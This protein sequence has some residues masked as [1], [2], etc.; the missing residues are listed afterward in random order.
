MEYIK[1]FIEDIIMAEHIHTILVMDALREPGNC[2]FCAMYDKLE[3]NSI[4]FIMGPAYM[5][6]DVRMATDKVGF[7]N[8]HLALMYKEQNRL[9]LGLML[10]SHIKKIVNDMDKIIKSPISGSFFK[11]E[12]SNSLGKMGAYLKGINESCYICEKI[13]GTFNRYIDT[14]LYLYNKDTPETKTQ[15]TYCLPHFIRLLELASQMSKSKRDKFTDDI[16]KPILKTI[17]EL[18]GDLD[19]FVS[20]FDHRNANEPWKN[21]KD[22]LPRALSLLCGKLENV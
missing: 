9:G 8:R 10:H 16:L 2:A 1:V 17:S 21:S 18:E 4:Q 5:E 19:W 3:S 22:A 13:E 15:K 14:F 7:C 12:Q 11:K 6:D 20:K